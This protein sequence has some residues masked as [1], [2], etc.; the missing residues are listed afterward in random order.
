MKS[1]LVRCIIPLLEVS[2]TLANLVFR[3]CGRKPYVNAPAELL[4]EITWRVNNLST[5]IADMVINNT[6]QAGIEIPT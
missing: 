5:S 2:P 3:P 1:G 6:T 4:Q